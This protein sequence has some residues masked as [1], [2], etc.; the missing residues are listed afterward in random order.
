[1][2]GPPDLTTYFAD[3]YFAAR[4]RFLALAENGGWSVTSHEMRATGPAGEPLNIDVAVRNG[5]VGV[6]GRT[7]I[8]SSGLHGVEGFLGSAVQCAAMNDF[9][10][11]LM[12]DVPRLIFI[13]GLNPYGFAWIR[14]CNEDNVDLNRNFPVR[15][16]TYRGVPD[17]YARFD[18]LL[19]KKS[20]PSKWEPFRILSL[21]AI[22]RYGI[23]R[24]KQAIAAGQY[25]FPLGLFYGGS[26][27]CETT[28]FVQEEFARWLGN[29]SGEILHLDFHTGLGHAGDFQLLADVPLSPVQLERVRTL[30]GRDVLSGKQSSVVAYSARGSIS[31]WCQTAA[32]NRDYTYLCVEFGT[33]SPVKVLAALRAEN[34]AHHWDRPQSVTYRWAKERLREAF[35]PRSLSWRR[36]A[37]AHGLDLVRRAISGKESPRR[38]R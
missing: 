29:D 20:P 27:P 22:L 2:D 35:C 26:G 33:Y 7:V 3:D 38:S 5:A 36:T 11:G 4:R 25:E 34:R 1:M 24:L 9:V 17:G 31:E 13:H 10:N 37:A 18:G 19:N 16:N 32:E 21:L 28:Q 15:G 23:P 6:T 30:F 14:R 8:V 12:T